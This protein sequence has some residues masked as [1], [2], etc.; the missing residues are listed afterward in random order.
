[1]KIKIDPSEIHLTEEELD[2]I[3]KAFSKIPEQY[4]ITKDE[5]LATLNEVYQNKNL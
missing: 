1:M 3:A 4:I 2:E 5:L